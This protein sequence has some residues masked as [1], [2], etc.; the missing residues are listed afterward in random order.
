M[1]ACTDPA[2]RQRIANRRHTRRMVLR[3]GARLAFD[4]MLRSGAPT[5]LLLAPLTYGLAVY[6]PIIERL[7][8][9]FRVITM[10]PRGMGGSDPLV[11]PYSVAQHA[12]DVRAVLEAAGGHV[13]AVGISSLAATTLLRLV[14]RHPGYVDWLVLVGAQPTRDNDRPSIRRA[15]EIFAREGVEEAIRDLGVRRSPTEPGQEPIADLW[16]A[17]RLAGPRETLLSFFDSDPDTD[18]RGIL[19]AIRIPVL[20]THGT[21][22]RAAQFERAREM[23][24]AIPG[25][26]FYAFEGRGHALIITATGEFCE[27]LRAFV[28]SGTVPGAASPR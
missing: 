18:V 24:A 20:V 15:R 11:R 6:Q 14:A 26:L 5:L 10:D 22:D 21:A 7:C 1:A 28:Q 17:A 8:Q 2:E 9:D 3:D 13:V 4:D 25:A 27:V 23:A 19:P 12:E 16:I